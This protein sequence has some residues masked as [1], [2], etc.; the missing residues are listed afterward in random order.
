MRNAENSTPR[1]RVP[2]SIKDRFSIGTA[3]E[4]AHSEQVAE[5]QHSLSFGSYLV[6]ALPLVAAL[7]IIGKLA[8]LLP[9]IVFPFLFLLYALP[10][11]IGSM[12]NVVVNR[13]YR[14]N[15]YNPAGKLSDCN[16]KWLLWMAGL[17]I[18]ALA[19]AL[20]FSL[21]APGWN[22]MEWLLIWV[23]AIAYYWIFRF[24]QRVCRREFAPKYSK[25]KALGASMVATTIVLCL[26]YAMLS[27]APSLNAQIDFADELQR[28]PMLFADSSCAILSE[29]DKITTFS[30][31]VVQYGLHYIEQSSFL[32][33]FFIQIVLSASI[34]LGVVSQFNACLLTRFEIES[35]FKKLPAESDERGNSFVRK[36]YLAVIIVIWV[37]ASAVF[38]GAEYEVSKTRASQ[39]YT[40]IDQLVERTTDSIVIATNYEIDEVL[41]T[42][43]KNEKLEAID[44]KNKSSLETFIQEN[45]GELNNEIESYYQSCKNNVDAYLDWCSSPQGGFA[46]MVKLFGKDMAVDRFNSQVISSTDSSSIAD[47]YNA[48]VSGL[49]SLYE[50]YLN[51]VNECDSEV[52]DRMATADEK[53]ANVPD[54]LDLWP[55]WNSDAQS[56]IAES[57]LLGAGLGFDRDSLKATILEYIDTERSAVLYSV[58]CTTEKAA[59]MI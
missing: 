4:K 34:F 46:R 47:A 26:V 59:N 2:S 45:E 12:F 5:Q 54:T 42:M 16:R 56:T 38:L 49:E 27:A 14:Q 6:R 25:A 31:F 33:A 37:V 51:E 32:I 11:A 8:P 41:D 23:A 15:R 18:L 29:L 22:D 20:L 48:Y 50:N 7:T 24:L 17:F 36:R 1:S 21:K 10:S 53:F 35:E 39:P 58:N 52:A 55:R 28:R 9:S 19:S 13:L 30:D 44:Q 40:A 57:Q 43:Q 3:A